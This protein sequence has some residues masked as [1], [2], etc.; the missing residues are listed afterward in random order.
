MIP[1]PRLATIA[2]AADFLNTDK[3]T[4]ERMIE[5]GALAHTS[6]RDAVRIPWD[7]LHALD[8][9]VVTP[10]TPA[11]TIVW[12]EDPE[13]AKRSRMR[14]IEGVA[15]LLVGYYQTRLARRRTPGWLPKLIFIAGFRGSGKTYAT[16]RCCGADAAYVNGDRLFN[17]ALGMLRPSLSK[18][19]RND[20]SKWPSGQKSPEAV[21]KVLAATIDEATFIVRRPAEDEFNLTPTCLR[22]HTDHIVVDGAIFANAWF[23]EGFE[24]LLAGSGKRFQQTAYLYPNLLDDIHLKH[25]RKRARPDELLRFP[26]TASVTIEKTGFAKCF[27]DTLGIWTELKTVGKLDRALSELL[28]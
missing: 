16:Y 26:D 9:S 12:P 13:E 2:Q 6:V 21:T 17:T 1:K 15:A 3:G 20:W 24:R 18:P 19:E 14:M 22:D 23:R 10:F 25:I 27:G 28:D 7:A 8:E 4:V 5:A 11:V